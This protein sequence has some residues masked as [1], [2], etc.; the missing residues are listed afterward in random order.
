MVKVGFGS[1]TVNDTIEPGEGHT[2]H[3][4]ITMRVLY[5]E[6]GEE[7]ALWV[8]T[9]LSYAA[10]AT[11]TP[12]RDVL[13]EA[14]GMSPERIAVHL[15]HLHVPNPINPDQMAAYARHMVP[16]VEEA[17][18]NAR[19]AQMAVVSADVGT[20]YSVNRTH[21]C[22]DDT[23]NITFWAGWRKH[24]DKADGAALVE[25]SREVMHRNGGHLW[26][27]GDDLFTS[28]QR[29][30]VDNERPPLL[31]NRPVDPLVQMMVFR[32]MDG[33]PMGTFTRFSTHPTTAHS[34]FES[35][36]KEAFPPRYNC[37]FIEYFRERVE[38]CIGG[39]CVFGTGPAGDLCP[40]LDGLEPETHSWDTTMAFGRALADEVLAEWERQAPK[41]QPVTLFRHR[42]EPVDMPMREDT[43]DSV[44][45]AKGRVKVLDDLMAQFVADGASLRAKARLR[46]AIS[47]NSLWEKNLTGWIQPSE[48]EVEDLTVHAW[49]TAIV[50]NDT[51]ILGL[52]GEHMCAMSVWLRGNT[53]GDRL[54]V[55]E[56]TDGDTGYMPSTENWHR[57]GY[58]HDI[59]IYR[60][61]CDDLV[62]QAALNL[63]REI[64]R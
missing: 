26:W 7:R 37:D 52:P 17:I 42:R 64:T 43:P 46:A 62:R 9:D 29:R 21:D 6:D 3:C 50:L 51:V 40:L 10:R 14:L 54:F 34:P 8:G 18:S 12:M 19:P 45:D 49:M 4:D 58:E 53:I 1:I 59:T 11:C 25:L 2:F 24:G 60:R 55:F 30:V 23:G 27:P 28:E 44:E 15:P 16:M 20:R 41:F 47:H 35:R 38:E 31:F 56:T 48:Q 33:Q 36:R 5:V 57:G 22:G 39:T 63:V 13:G 32:N 61:D